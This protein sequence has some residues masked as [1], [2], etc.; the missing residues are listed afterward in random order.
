MISSI[1]EDT[2]TSEIDEVI[3]KA[4]DS[5]FDFKNKSSKQRANF[6]YKIAQQLER[7]QSDLLE[8]AQSETNLGM[9]RLETE[10]IRTIDQLKG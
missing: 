10:L 8:T 3:D 7:I 6:L 4:N 1:Y 5:F 2:S 9:P